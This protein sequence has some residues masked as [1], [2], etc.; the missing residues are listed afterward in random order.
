MMKAASKAPAKVTK[1]AAGKAVAAKAQVKVVK[2]APAKTAPAKVTLAKVAFAKAALAGRPAAEKS[3]PPAV[4]TAVEPV[5]KPVNNAAAPVVA[6][7][8]PARPR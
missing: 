3:P 8:A 2:A 1:P 7:P 4:V 6:D 5:V